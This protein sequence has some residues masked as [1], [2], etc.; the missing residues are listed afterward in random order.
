[1]PYFSFCLFMVDISLAARSDIQFFPLVQK[2]VTSE[3]HPQIWGAR[4]PAYARARALITFISACTRDLI[5]WGAR[6][7]AYALTR[8]FD[9]IS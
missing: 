3:L 8:H 7:P 9:V 4:R 2:I 5:N 1:M 6:R